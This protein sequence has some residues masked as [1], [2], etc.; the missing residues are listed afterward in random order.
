[1]GKVLG[2]APCTAF[3][4]IANKLSFDEMLS[5]RTPALGI[6]FELLK[7]DE[8]ELDQILHDNGAMLNSGLSDGSGSPEAALALRRARPALMGRAKRHLTFLT[9]KLL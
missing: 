4:P 8:R 2:L 3:E 7:K 1:M 6:A 9:R 5:R